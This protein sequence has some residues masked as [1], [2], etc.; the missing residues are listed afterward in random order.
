MARSLVIPPDLISGLNL[1]WISPG[2]NQS[3]LRVNTGEAFVPGFMGLLEVKTPITPPVG[4]FVANNFYYCYLYNSGTADAPV[5]AV[6]L[7]THSVSPDTRPTLYRG[8]ARIKGTDNTRRY[9]GAVK[10]NADTP[11]R[12]YNTLRQ[13]ASVIYQEDTQFAPF[14][15]VSNGGSTTATTVG[16]GAVVPPT[17]RI[18]TLHLTNNSA[19]TAFFRNPGVAN[20]IV[21]PGSGKAI[22]VPSF[23]LDALQ[24]IT[25]QLNT[26]SGGVFIDVLGYAEER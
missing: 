25:Y 20:T 9:L 12:M 19:G 13:G 24:Q 23:P 16:L 15:V 21:A 14:R 18:A 5:A 26:G 8:T 7:V 4:S 17:S 10:T 2:T 6:E 22:V 11:A 1:E 3:Q